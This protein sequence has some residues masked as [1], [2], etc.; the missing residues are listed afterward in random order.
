E[1]GENGFDQDSRADRTPRN[2]KFIL[3]K[4]EHVIPKSR[5]QVALHLG[6]IEIW[7][8]TLRDQRLGIVEKIETKVEEGGRNRFTVNFEM[9]LVKMPAA[10]ADNQGRN[11]RI[12]L[13][14]LPFRAC[15]ADGPSDSVAQ[16]GLSFEI[17]LPRGRVRIFKIGHEHVGARVQRVDDH[18]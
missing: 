16:V 8:C 14:T 9:F 13:I 7:T 18:L 10:R 6:Q 3:G 2:A 12:E 4:A 5:L 15:V 11:M 1:S 17:V